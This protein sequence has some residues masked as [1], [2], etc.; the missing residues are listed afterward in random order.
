VPSFISE[1][2]SPKEDGIGENRA[3]LTEVVA[4]DPQM[5]AMAGRR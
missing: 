1:V 5:L 3:E 4:V 2:A